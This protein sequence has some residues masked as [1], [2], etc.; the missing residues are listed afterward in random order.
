MGYTA[1]QIVITAIIFYVTL[2]DAAPAFPVIIIPFVPMKLFL[3]NKIWG[4]E[5][6]RFVGPWA[7]TDGTTEDDEDRRDVF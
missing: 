7:C 2:T 1:L 5:T 3:V 4:R 6:L